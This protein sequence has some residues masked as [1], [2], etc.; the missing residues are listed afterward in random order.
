MPANYNRTAFLTVAAG[1]REPVL[2]RAYC[3]L[4]LIE[5]A[6]KEKLAASS[7]QHD[8][9]MMLQKLAQTLPGQRA[10]LNQH[11][12]EL[13]NRLTTLHTTRGDGSHGRVR[14][15][16]FPDLRYLRHE[17]DWT[18]DASRDAEL[19]ALRICVDRLRAFLKTNVGFRHPI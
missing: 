5:L 11:R 2:L 8:I 4:V 16:M 15:S 3:G 12:S 7:L 6:L 10:A 13:T 14:A 9:P 19:D 1:A 17:T 18:S